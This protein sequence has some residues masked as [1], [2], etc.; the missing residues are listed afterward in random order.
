MSQWA[1]R[2]SYK[3]NETSFPLFSSIT[4]NHNHEC[5]LTF[6]EKFSLSGVYSF[7]CCFYLWATSKRREQRT[8]GGKYIEVDLKFKFAKKREREGGRGKRER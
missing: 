8:N 4:C 2:K 7:S 5:Y 6:Y 3:L 1:L